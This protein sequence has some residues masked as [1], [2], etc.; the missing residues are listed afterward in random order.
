MGGFSISVPD[1]PSRTFPVNPRQLLWFIEQGLV[2]VPSVTSKEIE[3]KSKEDSLTQVLASGQ[4]M[5]FVAQCIGRGVH[6]LPVSTLEIT[7]MAYV[8]CML[9]ST[10][11]PLEIIHWPPGSSE[12]LDK[13]APQDRFFVLP[14]S[15]PNSIPASDQLRRH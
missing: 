8:A 5:W 4:T 1:D 10:P 7:T 9:P 12:R 13:L 2:Q 11:T 15:Q 3:D 6:R 14:A